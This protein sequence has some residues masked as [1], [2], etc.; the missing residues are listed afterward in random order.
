MIF[1]NEKKNRLTIVD[2][3]RP[4]NNISGGTNQIELIFRAFAR[5][6]DSLQKGLRAYDKG[7]FQVSFLEE[8][9]GGNFEAFETQRDHLGAV[10]FGLTGMEP[11]VQPWSNKS[12]IV[13]DQNA[14]PKRQPLPKARSSE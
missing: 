6:Y 4:E 1:T 5:A 2:P 12:K 8:L 7:D 11:V 13:S 14:Q 10:Y 3:N 9:I